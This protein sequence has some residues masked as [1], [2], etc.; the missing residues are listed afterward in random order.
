V[1]KWLILA[2]YFKQRLVQFLPCPIDFVCPGAREAEQQ[3]SF[4]SK[5]ARNPLKSHNKLS[6]KYLRAQTIDG[7]DLVGGDYKQ[8]M[9]KAMNSIDIMP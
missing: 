2:I 9:L 3:A 7:L 5:T 4:P 6:T 8:K 1:R